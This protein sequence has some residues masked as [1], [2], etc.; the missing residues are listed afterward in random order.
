MDG[1]FHS[2]HFCCHACDKSLSGLSYILRENNPFCIPCY[3]ERFA[4]TCVECNTK[5]E[6]DAKDLSFKNQ[7]YHETCFEKR[8]TCALCSESLADKAFGNWDG[9]LCCS[10]CYE[11]RLANKCQ[12]CNEILKP[13]MTRLGY[14]GKEWHEKCFRCKVCDKQIGTESFVPKEDCIYCTGCYEETFGTKCTGCGK[15]I[16]TGGLSYKKEP[17]HKE[18]FCCGGCGASLFNKRFTVREDNRFCADCFGEK[19]ARKCYS[20]KKPIVGQGGTKF[21]CFEE[22]NWH[23]ECFSCKK[24]NVSLVNECFVMDAEEIICPT[25]AQQG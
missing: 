25:C 11:T 5:I 4:N 23:N 7:H 22:R 9:K 14:G 2:A 18:C 1:S 15:L 12:V 13:G 20:C 21:V 8:Y 6:H 19:F 17:W 16:S 3:N 24:C 10:K